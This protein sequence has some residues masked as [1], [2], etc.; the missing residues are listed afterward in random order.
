MTVRAERV[1]TAA[2]EAVYGFLADLS[3]HYLISVRRLDLVAL[4]PGHTGGRIVIRGPL[5]IRR[6][7]RTAVTWAR[8]VT[9]FG[10]T[11]L[12]GR[13]TRAAVDWSVRDC[14]EGARV[15]LTARLDRAGPVDRLLLALGGRRWLARCFTHTL[16]R[17]ALV[18][19]PANEGRP[20]EGTA[21]EGTARH[22]G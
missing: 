4:S 1:V 8:P 15:T 14:A 12:V 3:N 2:P 10:G 21:R 16:A 5:G 20:W 13:R 6:T 9:A 7:A 22:D 17:L 19:G 18:L 11:A